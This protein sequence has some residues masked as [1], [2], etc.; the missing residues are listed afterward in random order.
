VNTLLALAASTQPAVQAAVLRPELFAPAAALLNSDETSVQISSIELLQ[1]LLRDQQQALDAFAVAGGAAGVT[2]DSSQQTIAA[3]S[4]AVVALARLLLANHENADVRQAAFTALWTV[5]GRPAAVA[6]QAAVLLCNSCAE[7][8]LAGFELLTGLLMHFSKEVPIEVLSSAGVIEAGLRLLGSYETAVQAAAAKAAAVLAW[9]L[10]GVAVLVSI[11][12]AVQQLVGLLRR[13]STQESAANA[14]RWIAENLSDSVIVYQLEA[15]RESC[16]AQLRAAGA[17]PAGLHLLKSSMNSINPRFKP[18]SETLT[19]VM[20]MLQCCGMRPDAAAVIRQ[21][22]GVQV[23][24]QLLV[25]HQ[26]AEVK[27]WAAGMLHQG[28]GYG[29]SL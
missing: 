9:N 8:Q 21:A 23:L 2:A 18:S 12:Q 26:D 28:L 16:C 7:T 25:E 14:L 15:V 24:Q 11:P 29:L 3:V 20:R 5:M 10:Q 1:L 27:Q 22:G 13:E 17:I 4:A 6:Q 19:S